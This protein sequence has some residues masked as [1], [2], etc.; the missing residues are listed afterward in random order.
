MRRVLSPQAKRQALL[1]AFYVALFMLVW[2]VLSAYINLNNVKQN[3][4]YDDDWNDLS[5]FREELKSLGLETQ[6]L[7][8]S[9]LILNEVEDPSNSS[10][11]I[12]GVERD[13]ISLPRFA[14]S[15]GLVSFKEAEG[16]T[17][18]EKEAIMSFVKRGGTVLVL[19]DF[20]Y[21]KTIGESLGVEYSGHRL[22]DEYYAHELDYNYV[23]MNLS[24]NHTDW[25]DP[26]T[27]YFGHAR[28]HMGTTPMFEGQ[29]PCASWS[30]QIVA[31]EDAGMC[32]HHWDA[33]TGT[34]EYNSS[35]SILLNGPSAFES[36]EF[37]S[38]LAYIET[39]GRSSAQSF[40][41]ENDDGKITL[42][43]EALGAKADLQGPFDMY[44]EA[45]YDDDCDNPY[46]GRI[47]FISDASMLINAIYDYDG[48]NS[49]KYGAS[50][51]DI[52]ANDNRMW[53][54]DFIAEAS[55]TN[56]SVL[57]PGNDAMVIFDESR[58]QQ[59]FLL[60]DAYNAIYYLLVYFTSD[61]VAML[62]LFIALFLTFE[63]VLIKKKDPDQWRHVF[64][65]IYYGFGDAKR[66]GYYAKSQKIK[67]VFL[68]RVRNLNALTR[69]EFDQM[70]ARELQS[71]IK[72]P[73]LVKFVFENRDYSLE[74]MV[75]V[76]KRIKS[77]ESKRG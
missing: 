63:A 31:L 24:Q 40:L 76:V 71:M 51:K 68:S 65:I 26:D 75:A 27:F 33:E 45:C 37:T 73:V 12:S 36:N 15:D 55:M 11:I 70:P 22:Y 34:I 50:G 46:G 17:T 54:L 10:F 19:D 39:I 77:W 69:D 16:Y 18:S 9:P 56:A 42:E 72:D 8:S 21:A 66:Y 7:V 3:S 23:W 38:E 35:Y 14:T 47:F 74:Q 48:Y 43:A 67:Q 4:A 2:V 61:G 13:T 58:H 62:F 60:S 64:S 6:S 41:D 1:A 44:I 28:W 57:T 49:Q 20:G 29:H 53:A 52:P 59:D 25:E 5:A 30:G 32:A